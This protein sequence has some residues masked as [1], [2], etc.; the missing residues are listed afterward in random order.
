[1]HY[2]DCY[3]ETFRDI[4]D[5]FTRESNITIRNNLNTTLMRTDVTLKSGHF[6]KGNWEEEELPGLV[7]SS[8]DKTTFSVNNEGIAYVKGPEGYV[9]YTTATPLKGVDN[10][11]IVIYWN[12]LL[13][14]TKSACTVTSYPPKLI[15]Y[16]LYPS[17]EAI[18]DW[19]QNIEIVIS[20]V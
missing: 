17:Q 5:L 4:N 15:G 7:I 1:M 20:E 8:G 12:N 14:H 10:P 13:G 3:D 18:D 19:S 2:N 9:T 11:R 6:K 16:T